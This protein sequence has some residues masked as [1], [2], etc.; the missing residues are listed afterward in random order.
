MDEEQAPTPQA[1]WRSW[2]QAPTPP[3]EAGAVIGPQP[4][5]K[6]R[7]IF[8]MRTFKVRYIPK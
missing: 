5:R 7:W 4:P 2:E 3:D 6:V 1:K 8:R